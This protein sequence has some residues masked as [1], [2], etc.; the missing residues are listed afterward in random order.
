MGVRLPPFAQQLRFAVNVKV[1]E[2]SSFKREL[3][4]ELTW[5]ELE[6]GLERAT[7]KI[8]KEAEIPGFRKGKAPRELIFA[9]FKE[10]IEKEALSDLINESYPQAL[11]QEGI[12]PI[13]CP[14]IAMENNRI[15]LGRSLTYRALFEV[16][17]EIKID[18]Y[19][20]LNL[21]KKVFEVSQEE[22]DGA[23]NRLREEKA[24]LHP[25]ES[26]TARKGDVVLI[27]YKLS[28]IEDPPIEDSGRSALLELGSGKHPADME[29]GIAGMK[30]GSTQE[31]RVR[32]P[33]DFGEKKFAGKV[34]LFHV[35]LHEIKEKVL[36]PL[37]ESFVK[38][39]VP[40]VEG[41]RTME[42]LQEF[43]KKK[44]IESYERLSS[45]D[46]I[47]QIG[48]QIVEQ[49]LFDAP[50]SLIARQLRRWLK[51]STPD[52]DDSSI[53]D[54]VILTYFKEKAPEVYERAEREV[55]IEMALGSVSEGEKIT[56]D[57]EAVAERLTALSNGQSFSEKTRSSLREAVEHQVV[58]EKTYQFLK[59]HAKITDV[60]G[61]QPSR[62]DH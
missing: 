38:V 29:E 31:M 20:K 27:D 1:K 55:K 50:T 59:E 15:A 49:N 42:D 62:T 10:Q 21:K 44:L 12:E 26:E 33:N 35:T 53:P 9:R 19:E 37:D 40:Q 22:I 18:K 48:E 61:K 36:P 30:A 45:E 23:I 4:V 3:K 41:V 47:G 46:L 8:S 57:E 39:M 56:A 28:T 7:N 25:S 58:R 16:L 14:E 54:E 5:D 43:V 13:C 60:P 52:A 6:A 34:A 2:L 32:F 51:Q 17:P 24:T 11:E